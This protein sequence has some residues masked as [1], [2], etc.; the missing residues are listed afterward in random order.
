MK[1]GQAK[2]P[3]LDG[4]RQAQKTNPTSYGVPGH[5]SGQGAGWDITW[6]LGRGTFKGD[7][8]TFKGIDD[9]RMSKRV[10]QNSEKL[11]AKACDAEH[12]FFSTN[13]TSLSNHVAMLTVAGPGDTV[14]MSRNSH[15]SLYAAAIIGHVKVTFLE[16]DYDDD[17]NV[18]H[19]IPVEEVRRKLASHP[20]AKAV[21]VVSPTYYGV[22]SVLKTIAGVCHERGVPLVVDEAW[23]PHYA[24]HPSYPK[25][26][27]RCGV[28]LA[29]SSI[30]KTMAGL[31]GASILL[32]NSYDRFTLVYDLFES[33]SPSVP[34]LA[35]I[36]ATRRQFV[37]SGRKLLGTLLDTAKNA[38]EQLASIEGV[39][40]IGKEVKDND[41]RF[42]I[43]EAKIFIDIT[44]LGVN[45]YVADEWL[46]AE[47]KMSMSLSDER[48]LLATLT[49][50]NKAG[51]ASTLAKGIRK[52][53]DWASTRKGRGRLAV[54][55]DVPP[56]NELKGKLMMNPSKAFFAKAEH[57]PLKKAVGRIAAEMISP[58]PPGIPRVVPGERITESQVLYLEAGLRIGLFAMDPVI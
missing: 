38:R 9:R 52:L 15:K 30:H 20:D 32:L 2:A 26:A 36:D 58:Y 14:L 12:C 3:I 11:A 47:Q 34:I 50:G 1:A 19:G 56:L 49:I 57:V 23:G 7:S 44:G 25:P 13:G 41:A 35:S 39:R 45:G 21:F 8:T 28:D 10:R 40:V 27:I 17:W 42:A 55:D 46:E 53:A 31:E 29:V 6:L 54:P 18:E 24:F 48:H 37:E 16:P 5:K 51:D 22:S 33:T 43:E 4:L